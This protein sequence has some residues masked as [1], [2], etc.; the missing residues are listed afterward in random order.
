[1]PRKCDGFMEN[2]IKMDDLGGNTPI[3]GN[4]Q[5]NQAV[6]FREWNGLSFIWAR[7]WGGKIFEHHCITEILVTLS[8]P[9]KKG[10]KVS[11]HQ[12]PTIM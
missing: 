8:K 11:N 12:S 1:M 9:G 4:T 2:P 6:S 10:W 7:A 5:G 3:C